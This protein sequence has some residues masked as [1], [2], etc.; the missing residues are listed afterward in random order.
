[1]LLTSGRRSA[2]EVLLSEPAGTFAT[3][4][5][6]VRNLIYELTDGR[7]PDGAG[8][9]FF[10]GYADF[11]VEGEPLHLHILG[12]THL[13]EAPYDRELAE[14]MAG[15]VDD[16]GTTVNPSWRPDRINHNL[17]S[18]ALVVEYKRTRIVLGGDMEKGAWE[19]VLGESRGRRPKL[20]CQLLKVSHHGSAT[21]YFA[22]L[23][24]CFS[25]G[26]R[27]LAG[28]CPVQRRGVP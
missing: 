22:G 12:P 4:L 21:G 15:L 5:M 10:S 8:F 26:G 1:A 13:L 27:V 25:R 17:V 14:N 11:P 24:E 20:R 2:I 28:L 18:P 23:Y 7:A 16:T 9:R 3:E 19:R 6:R